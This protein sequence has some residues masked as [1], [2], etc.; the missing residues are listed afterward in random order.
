[1]AVLAYVSRRMHSSNN[2]ASLLQ[3]NVET[4]LTSARITQVQPSPSGNSTSYRRLLSKGGN[5]NGFRLPERTDRSRD[6]TTSGGWIQI[7]AI[8]LACVRRSLW[9]RLPCHSVDKYFG[10]VD[11]ELLLIAN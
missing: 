9:L 8:F 2:A 6:Q 4:T 5:R 3:F 1:M 7:S 10:D 11:V